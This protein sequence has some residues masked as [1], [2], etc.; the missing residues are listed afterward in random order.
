MAYVVSQRTHEIGVRIA[1]CA[2]APEVFGLDRSHG[3]RLTAVGMLFGAAGSFLVSRW[4]K[5]LLLVCR[6]EA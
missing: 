4:L 3:L 1:L 2:A 6:R 5:S